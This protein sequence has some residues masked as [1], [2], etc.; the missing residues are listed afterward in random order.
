VVVLYDFSLGMSHVKSLIIL[1]GLLS[2]SQ[3][4]WLFSQ[5]T[6]T[7][8]TSTT[9]VPRSLT[10][11]EVDYANPGATPAFPFDNYFTLNIKNYPYN[12]IRCAKIAY[13]LESSNENIAWI[14]NTPS[15][16]AADG[17]IYYL[18][19]QQL[20]PNRPVFLQ[21]G[22][23]RPADKATK[24]TLLNNLDK[25]LQD[26]LLP[27]YHGLL[28]S[29]TP[30]GF[31]ELKY[32]IDNILF[33]CAEKLDSIAFFSVP[34][35]ELVTDEFLDS[36]TNLLNS[37]NLIR[38]N[39][40]YVV[41]PDN[42][43]L[44]LWLIES[45]FD[46]LQNYGSFEGFLDGKVPLDYLIG[47]LHNQLNKSFGNEDDSISYVKWKDKTE[48]MLKAL[49]SLN[50]NFRNFI[51][52]FAKKLAAVEIIQFGSLTKGAR[53]QDA[54]PYA[55]FDFGAILTPGVA[56]PLFTLYGVN[57]HLWPIN[58][59]VPLGYYSRRYYHQNKNHDFDL[60]RFLAARTSLL[61]GVAS[62]SFEAD[63]RDHLFGNSV[64]LVTGIGFRL[65]SFAQVNTGFMWHEVQEANPADT[66]R[67]QLGFNGFVGLAFTLD[68]LTTGNALSSVF[69]TTP[70]G[71]ATTN[72]AE[73]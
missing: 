48:K 58:R 54:N 53:T 60:C 70:P 17:N 31:D 34:R 66:D 59:S 72:T 1:I 73:D 22:V 50:L 55:M 67:T 57:L 14:Q 46:A 30:N 56:G 33:E 36:V 61:V 63:E 5:N 18:V 11:I 13:S 62:G 64:S 20:R 6:S 47:A 2:C 37:L 29:S 51:L 52:P 27:I 69:S 28:N 21:L 68:F 25:L 45:R 35:E 3:P 71:A 16:K 7:D 40:E 9:I 23:Y 19:N 44:K 65:T 8:E 32:D 42:N 10:V 38:N 49:E 26:N 12:E 15:T 4:F 39:F 43:T 24:D 41:N